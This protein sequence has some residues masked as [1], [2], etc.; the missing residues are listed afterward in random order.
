MF[1]RLLIANRG[2]IACRVIRCC[3]RLGIESVA[4]YSDA[5]ANARHVREADRA[6]RIGPAPARD[7]YL[8]ANAILRAALDTG[9]EAIHPG[10][11][12]LSE[13]LELIDACRQAGI[14]FIGPHR[15]AIARMGSKIESKRLAREAGVA[16]VPGYDG[17]DQSDER[18][19]REATAL[20]YPL[21]IKASAGGG[22]KGL[23]RV[24]DTR[25]FAAQLATARAEARAAFGDERVLLERCITRPR[26]VEVQL[27]GDR[28]GGLVHLFERECSIQRNYQKLV[29]EAPAAHLDDRIRERLFDAAL[30]LGRA[31]GY[32]SAGTVEFVLDAAR[33]D[34]PYFLEMNTRLQVEHPVTEL[35]TG[36][37]LVEWQIRVA[38]G[39]R[40]A[41]AQ[42][43]VQRHGWAIEARVNAEAPARGYAASF[44]PVSGYA[45]PAFEGLRVDSGID[46]A[47]EV[48]PHYDSMLM[49]LIAQGGSREVATARLRRALTELRIEG[50]ETNQA[51][52]DA[53]LGHANFATKLTTAY[54][55]EAFP[56]GWQAQA[57]AEAPLAAAAAWV[58]AEAA[59][60]ASDRP[61]DSLFGLRLTASAGRP[62]T[63]EVAVAGAEVD[64]RV[65]VLCLPNSE[66]ECQ[67]GEARQC[68]TRL[69]EGLRSPRAD[70]R[71]QRRSEGLGLWSAGAW[72]EWTVRS[73]LDAARAEVG[74]GPSGDEV[75]AELP[76]I[77]TALNVRAGDAVTAGQ[78]VAVLE[79][80]KLVHTLTAPRDGVVASVAVTVGETL[81]GG[82]VLIRLAPVG[83]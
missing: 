47:S 3:R 15:E 74:A 37:D 78:P 39:E 36:I 21:L 10:Y 4:V 60:H 17:D 51:F 52:L 58:F 18:L 43:D 66:V 80:M 79:A 62:A 73:A 1:K 67:A 50:V 81:A 63:F 71:V 29:E 32:D 11:G 12:F 22:G 55:Q 8:D 25:D 44:G 69:P 57:G 65:T 13:K 9:A 2:E 33:D 70:Y 64:L 77:V 16:C 31:I 61:L 83:D 23:R 72:S 41:L 30:A 27:L 6:V 24:D 46:G 7:S 34:E 82:T 76:G 54:L 5:D 14:V 75:R 26:H 19:A 40:L 56:A 48:T 35:T 42:A 28:H 49:K 38:A 53:V 20:G 68:F 59:R 45:A